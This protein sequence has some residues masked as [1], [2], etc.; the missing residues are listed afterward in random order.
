MKHMLNKLLCFLFLH[1]FH[2]L[3]EGNGIKLVGCRRCPGRWEVDMREET[4]EPVKE[5]I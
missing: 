4:M 5:D 3:E 2:T 1:N